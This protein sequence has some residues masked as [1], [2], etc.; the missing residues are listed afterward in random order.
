LKTRKFTN[1]FTGKA[2]LLAIISIVLIIAISYG[3]FFYLEN[4]TEQN[5][6]NSII[7]Q[8]LQ[9]QLRDVQALSR[10]IGTDLTL[11][12]D[13]LHGLANSK[14]VQQGDLSSDKITKLAQDTYTRLSGRESIIDR[15]VIADKTGFETIGLAAKGQKSFAG[16]NISS[17]PWVQE[18]LKSKTPTFSNGFVG[19]DGNYRIA[20]GYPIINLDNG[21]YVGMI[22][23]LVPFE[24]FL[25]QYGNIHNINSKYL[26][27]YDKNAT[28]L[29]T[30]ASKTLIGKNFFGD[31]VQQFIK[32]NQILNKLVSDLLAGRPSYGIYNY[33]LGE[34]LTTGYPVYAN[35]KAVYF[36]NVVSPTAEIYS[37]ISDVLFAERVKMFSLIAGTTAAVAILIVFLIKWS[38]LNEEI[39]RRAKELEDANKQ[40]TAANEQLKIHDK[41]QREFINVASH[42]IKTPTQAILSY[43]DILRKHPERREQ[44]SDALHRNAN[45]LQRLTNDILDITRIESQTLKL[46][47]EKFNLTELVSTIVEDFKNDIQKNSSDVKLLYEPEDSLVV[48]ADKQRITQVISNLLSNAIKFTREGSISINV[49]KRLRNEGMKNNNQEVVVSVQD[50]GTGIDPEILPRLFTKFATK[51]NIGGTGL[52]LFISKS[53]VESHGGKMW[54]KNNNNMI[55]NGESRGAIFYFSLPLLTNTKIQSGSNGSGNT[56]STQ[57]SKV[58]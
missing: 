56:E 6:R 40:L 54:G 34:R 31:Y 27:A 30:A 48:E 9:N 58:E 43:T 55:N 5:I 47:K 57:L 12:V 38:G 53:I 35:G 21:Q 29:A 3:L 39:K 16:T 15:L 46:N 23:A 44:I 45:R 17:R 52:G 41:M 37:Q 10:H 22:G 42:E 51:S 25:S 11:V 18:T 36:I 26:A 20:I 49:L 24:S 2:K 7:Q 19:L 14:Y 13:N 1:P 8:Q 33:G 50:T 32:H 4:T 28:I